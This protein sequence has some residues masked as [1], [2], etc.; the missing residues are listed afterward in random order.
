LNKNKTTTINSK[1]IFSKCQENSN[2]MF[3]SVRKSVP[4][5]HQS[6]TNV[7]QEFLQSFENMVGL[8]II[9]QKEFVQKMGIASNTPVPMLNII[10]NA[11]EEFVKVSSTQKQITLTTIDAIQEN[12]KIFNDN[13]TSFTDLN[14]K[15]LQY[16]ISTLSPKCNQ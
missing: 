4:Q 12:I 9:I 10:D 1:D 5:Y 15:I 8:F 6:T 7:Q 2:K 14:K 11:S 3:D 13:V 16:W